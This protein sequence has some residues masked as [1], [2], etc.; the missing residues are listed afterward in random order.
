MRAASSYPVWEPS[1]SRSEH[2]LKIRVACEENVVKVGAV[3]QILYCSE[4][5]ERGI[6][7]L[8]ALEVDR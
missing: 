4:V 3:Q 5:G 2:S 6:I 8:L 7:L 1:A